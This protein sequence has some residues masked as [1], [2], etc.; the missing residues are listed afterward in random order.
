MLWT[1]GRSRGGGPEL[2]EVQSLWAVSTEPARSVVDDDRLPTFTPCTWV[3]PCET[4]KALPQNV[5][6]HIGTPAPPQI[7]LNFAPLSLTFSGAQTFHVQVSEY[8]Y[9]VYNKS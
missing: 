2:L 7:S 8:I 9:N 5:S 6:N 4:G 1:A 3:C